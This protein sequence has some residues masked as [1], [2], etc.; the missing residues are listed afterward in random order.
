MDRNDGGPA[1][2]VENLVGAGLRNIDV[3]P[4]TGAPAGAGMTLRDYFAAKAMQGMLA[5]PGDDSR[6]SHHNNNTPDGVASMAYS[7]AGAMLAER[8][9]ERTP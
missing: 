5:Y 1:F 7:Y 4:T 3:N 2:P 6:G 9:K 8:A